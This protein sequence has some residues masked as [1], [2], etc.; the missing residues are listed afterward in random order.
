MHKLRHLLGPLR[1]FDAVYRSGGISR[2][3]DALHVTPG[4]VSQQIKQLEGRLGVL[5][6][7]KAGRTV[8]SR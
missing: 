1:V 4:A 6:V 8:L 3:A 5:L 7:R 2:G